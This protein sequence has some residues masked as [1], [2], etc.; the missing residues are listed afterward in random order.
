MT[1]A[2]PDKKTKFLNDAL[3]DIRITARLTPVLMT[4]EW[5]EWQEKFD[6]QAKTVQKLL[7]QKPDGL[8][9]LTAQETPV[10]AA[11]AGPSALTPATP[12]S[13]E[14]AT[15]LTTASKPEQSGGSMVLVI[16]LVLGLAVVVVVVVVFAMRKSPPVRRPASAASF[17]AMTKQ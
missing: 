13:V 11:N 16:A 3:N 6:A 7:N 14:P 17:E 4:P 5:L 12:G 2:T 8:S 1:E 9:V 15:A 10:E